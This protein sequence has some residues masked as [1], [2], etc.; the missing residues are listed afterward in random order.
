MRCFHSCWSL[1]APRSLVSMVVLLG[2]FAVEIAHAEEVRWFRYT[3]CDPGL[4][5]FSTQQQQEPFRVACG[6]LGTYYFGPGDFESSGSCSSASHGD[7][8]P[9]LYLSQDDPRFLPSGAE[10]FPCKS[11]GCFGRRSQPWVAVVDWNQGHG[12]SVAGLIREV[13]GSGVDLVLFPLER[14]SGLAAAD[15]VSD[16]DVLIQLCAVAEAAYQAPQD[17]PLAVNM[18]FG[19]LLDP[20]VSQSAGLVGRWA[21]QDEIGRV[22][23]HL[24]GLGIQLVAA[25]GNHAELL[26][27]ASHSK[28]MSVGS[29]D[30]EHWDSTGSAQRSWQTPTA[31]DTLLPAYGLYL[32]AGS[33][34]HW[35]VPPGSSY[36]SAFATGWLAGY[37]VDQGMSAT[38]LGMH[39]G[40]SLG[41]EVNSTTYQLTLDGQPL[42]GSALSGA[43]GLLKRALEHPSSVCPGLATAPVSVTPTSVTPTLPTDSADELAADRN[44][45]LPNTRPCVPCHGRVDDDGLEI[46]LSSSDGLPTGWDLDALYLM[47]GSSYYQISDS[48]VLADFV[49]GDLVALYLEDVG[50][51]T[52]GTPVALVYDIGIG[53]SDEFWDATPIHM[54]P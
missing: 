28:V 35:P 9:A 11:G 36:A 27:P 14:T 29:V 46:D 8:V 30:I 6:A 49:D 50:S 48:T 7:E 1:S 10:W 19:R 4:S 38:Q 21:F 22:L 12:W 32:D 40:A 23:D 25:A 52:A 16:L 51:I 42:S 41:F 43:V 34:S 18:S 3:S 15:G 47:I 54:H 2:L 39:S 5:S 20:S 44:L 37:L 31:A 45:P 53:T 24:S 26:F 33:G 13:A 17:L